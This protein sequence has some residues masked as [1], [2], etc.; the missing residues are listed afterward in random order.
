MHVPCLVVDGTSY[1]LDLQIVD[2]TPDV[3]LKLT[4]IGVNDASAT[5]GGGSGGMTADSCISSG[6]YWCDGVCQ[7]SPCAS[8]SCNDCS[9]AEYANAN[10]FECGSTG[11]LNFR[12]TWSD[13]NDVDLHVVYNN[14]EEEIY[15]SMPAGSMTGGELDVD[16]NAACWDVVSNP[17]ENIYYESP[18]AGQYV[19]KVCGYESCGSPSSSVTAQILQN[20][21][22]VWEETLNISTWDNSCVDV[23]S[24]SL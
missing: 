7:A 4:G 17:V 2:T 16:A 14:G 18:P 3:I 1:W 5:C 10:P 9:C 13:T 23:Y 19:M 15:F 11:A 24:F 12:I 20:G 22:V 21:T 6:Q 8:D